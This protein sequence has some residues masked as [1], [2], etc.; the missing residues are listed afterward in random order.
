[1]APNE[2][3]TR[4]DCLIYYADWRLVDFP[5]YKIIIVLRLLANHI[6]LA[7]YCKL[8]RVKW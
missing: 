4:E 7:V 8:K 5:V 2:L 6:R 1:M 3:V